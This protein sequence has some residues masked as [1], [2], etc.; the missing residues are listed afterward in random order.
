MPLKALN[1]FLIPNATT[2]NIAA[3]NI[4]DIVC[5]NPIGLIKPKACDARAIPN[6]I[7]GSI[8]GKKI[9]DFAKAPSE[10]P[11]NALNIFLI[12]NATTENTPPINIAVAA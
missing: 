4:A 6:A 9:A 11:L 2:E 1:I 5:N 8:S 7:A 3:T 10:I 12:P